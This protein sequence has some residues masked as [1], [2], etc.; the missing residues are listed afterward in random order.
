MGDSFYL[1]QISFNHHH[2]YHCFDHLVEEDFEG[3]A[4]SFSYKIMIKKII[5]S[6]RLLGFL[7]VKNK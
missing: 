7:V 2:G 5:L 3:T 4:K 6:C 1:L